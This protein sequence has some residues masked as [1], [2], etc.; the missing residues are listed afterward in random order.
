MHNRLARIVKPDTGR[1][2]MVA[3]DHGYFMG[4]TTR[5]ERPSK[6]I[7]PLLPYA[8]SLMLTRGVLRT[9]VD[10]GADIAIVLRVSG[11]SSILSEDL[12]NEGMA[13]SIKEALRL[14]AAAVAMSVFLGSQHEKESILNLAALVNEAE[15]WGIPVLAVTAVGRELEK[16]DARYLA[17][18]CRITAEMGAR[19]VKTYYCDGF[20]KVVHGCPVPL[21]VA[22]GPKLNSEM[23][24]FQLAYQALQEGAVGVDMGRNIWQ[25]D[26]PVAMIRAIREV[27][28]HGA[29]PG[30]AQEVFEASKREQAAPEGV[31]S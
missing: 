13:A 24:V 12:S 8:D 26:Y 16:R 25:H 28:H 17:L 29:S 22:G 14:N 30:E 31:V 18:A 10:P 6:S 3:V 5:L 11:G 27:V 15:E 9:S 7:R 21:V 20:E 23:E 4:P 2:V 1:T 19:F